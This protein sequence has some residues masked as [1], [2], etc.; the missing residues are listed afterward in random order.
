MLG[1]I[2][3]IKLPAPVDYRFLPDGPLASRKYLYYNI[4]DPG[5]IFEVVINDGIATLIDCPLAVIP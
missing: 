3:L 4:D 2:S 1:F 5:F